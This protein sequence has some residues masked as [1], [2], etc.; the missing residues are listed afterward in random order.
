MVKSDEGDKVIG[1]KPKITAEENFKLFT[2]N[3]FEYLYNANWIPA[4]Q[5]SILTS[6]CAVKAQEALSQNDKMASYRYQ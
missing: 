5:K 1:V 6:Y 4:E 2:E 3:S